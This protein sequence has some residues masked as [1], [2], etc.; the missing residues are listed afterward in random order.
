MTKTKTAFSKATPQQQSLLGVA[1]MKCLD[2]FDDYLLRVKGVAPS[3]R[4]IYCLWVRR[5][6]AGF[7]GLA[8]TAPDWSALRGSD[9]AIFV[10]N[11]ASR[12]QRNGR[13][14]PGIAM[15]AF[16]RYLV[17]LGLAQEG[18][19]GAIPQRPRWRH[20][21]L[22]RFLPQADV[23]R[24]VAAALDD[25]AAGRRNYAILLLLSRTGLRA[26]E[27]AQLSLDDIDWR[28]GVINVRSNKSRNERRL[29]LVHDVGAAIVDYLER[30]RPPCHF[31][32]IFLRVIP[33]FEP[34]LG[35]SGICRLT[36]RA[37]SRA[38]L[39]TP[40]AAHLF[41]HTAATRMIR[42]GASFKEIADVLGHAAI[43]TT[44]IY[45][46]LDTAGLSRVAMPWPGAAP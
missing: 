11:E 40:A 5:F 28:N 18:L 23:D 7:C 46:K 10:G 43:S 13:R 16:V 26:H 24:V 25:T 8:A 9:L 20:V 12:L 36:R 21:E 3:T 34:F 31:R 19:C 27:V 39:H 15:R 41:R 22:P 32:T 17:F 6:L 42:G 45:A 14:I 29:P 2:K 38:D 1:A 35:S 44:A 4:K 37:L 33:P 30:G